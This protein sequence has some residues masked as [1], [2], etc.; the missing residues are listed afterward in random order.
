MTLVSNGETPSCLLNVKAW[1]VKSWAPTENTGNS[2][3]GVGGGGEGHQGSILTGLSSLT[4]LTDFCGAWILEP[5][6]A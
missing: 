2:G 1:K 3:G 6:R 5:T 4:D